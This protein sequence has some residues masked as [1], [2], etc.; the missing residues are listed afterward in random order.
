MEKTR[1][2]TKELPLSKFPQTLGMLTTNLIIF[3][4]HSKSSKGAYLA[5]TETSPHSH[6][7]CR[8]RIT[9]LE[10]QMNSP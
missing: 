9:V 5:I 8:K 2:D 4:K 1:C 6:V 7:V 3:A 10:M